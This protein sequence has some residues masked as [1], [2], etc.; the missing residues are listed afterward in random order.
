MFNDLSDLHAYLAT[1]RSGRPR[2]MIAPGPSADQLR[3]IVAKASRTP[4]HGKLAPWRVVHIGAN[5]RDAFAAALRAAYLAEKPE[6]GRLELETM[7]GFARQAPEILVVL[8]SPRASSKIPEWEQQLSAGAFVMNLLHAAHSLGFVGG[9][10]TG[11][12]AYSDRVRDLF[13]APPERIAGFVFIGTPG[14]ALEERPRPELE[15][16][17]SGWVPPAR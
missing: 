4:D 3:D 12:P 16:V 13:G 9:W 2:D 10:I 11:W 14:A 15:T 1:R 6:A 17:L 5:Q 7:D 8:H